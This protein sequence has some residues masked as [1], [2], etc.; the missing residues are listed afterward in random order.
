MKIGMITVYRGSNYGALLQSFATQHYIESLGFETEIITVKT[1]QSILGTLA[2]ASKNLIPVVYRARL[3][4]VHKWRY[5][6]KHPHLYESDR[7][8]TK[9]G[10]E[11]I[12][13]Y[14]HNIVTYQNMKELEFQ[15]GAKYSTVLIGSDQQWTPQCYYSKMSTLEFV[16][17]KTNKVSYATSLGVS[18][19]PWYSKHILKRFIPRIQHVSVRENTGRQLIMNVTGRE[20]V[21]VVPDPT[22]LL[23]SSD[24]NELIRPAQIGEKD[25][26]FCYFLGNNGD[27]MKRTLEFA[28]I[29]GL[30]VVAVRN[31][32]V[33]EE[34]RTDYGNAKILE[35]PDVEEFVNYIRNATYVFTDSFHATVFSIINH[36]QFVT[37]YRMRHS[38]KGSRNSRIDDFLGMLHLESRI[39]KDNRNIDQI[40]AND[41]QFDKVDKHLEQMRQIGS[42]FL[43]GA[44]L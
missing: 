8:R 4:V 12:D 35:A 20:D 11:F 3:K 37:F 44:L 14:L 40:V 7:L 24:W 26:I 15:A 1:D 13:K 17:E 2:R 39:A 10:K 42:L 41:I 21:Q 25:Y 29:T 30:K 18:T 9:R 43:K 36:T 27:S 16:P 33:F 6:K 28:A 19:L 5:L 31:I 23:T 32:E 22:L 34:D 38:D